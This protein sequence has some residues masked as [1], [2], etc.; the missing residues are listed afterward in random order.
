MRNAIVLELTLVPYIRA[1]GELKTKPTQQSVGELRRIGIQPDVLIIRCE[2]PLEEDLRK[3]IALFCNVDHEAVIEEMDVATSI[4]EVPLVLYAQGLDRLIAEHLSLPVGRPKIADW[5]EMIENIK[6]P[7]SETVIGVVG[8]YGLQDAYKSIYEALSHAGAH[9]KT[10]VKIERID[11]EKVEK[12]GAEQYLSH[13]DGLLVPGGFGSRGIEGKIEAIRYARERKL[14]FFGICL[15]MQCAVIEFGRNVCGMKTANSS[16]FDDTPSCEPVIHL[17]PG[18]QNVVAKGGTMRLGAYP[19]QLRSDSKS[20]VAYGKENI[21]ERHRHRYEFNNAN[22]ERFEHKGM[23]VMGQSPDG[24]LVEI[25]EIPD[26]PWFVG[27]QFHPEFKSQP[28]QPQ[29]LFRDF[30]GAAANIAKLREKGSG[31]R[32]KSIRR[33]HASERKSAAE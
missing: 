13:I 22:R 12:H 11:A 26:H 15:G 1:A 30:I 10:R 7:R 4:Y 23:Q 21:S 27:V 32:H 5:I 17:M 2:K 20:F 16:E 6:E 8:K 31:A 19:C 18:Q 24:K 33:K 25:I 14:P 29:P 28:T 3:K 9:H